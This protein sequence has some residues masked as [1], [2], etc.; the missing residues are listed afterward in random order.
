VN[1]I[2]VLWCPFPEQ[3]C[4]TPRHLLIQGEQLS[5]W[6]ERQPDTL[7]AQR[8]EKLVAAAERLAA[9]PATRI[10]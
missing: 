5:V 2:T 1:A 10:G 7:P 3:E 9:P 4:P 6:L 8:L